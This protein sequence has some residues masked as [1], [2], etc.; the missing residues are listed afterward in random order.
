[1]SYICMQWALIIG[2]STLDEE[3]VRVKAKYGP[4]PSE[5][6]EGPFAY[7][8]LAAAGEPALAITHTLPASTFQK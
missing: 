8:D 2:T 5:T 1:M 6:K 4:P 7:G 3:E